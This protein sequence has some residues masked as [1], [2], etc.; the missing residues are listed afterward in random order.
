[1]PSKKSRFSGRWEERNVMN[2]GE[3]ISRTKCAG[4]LLLAA[5]LQCLTAREA[6]DAGFV[7]VLTNNPVDNTVIQYS[8]G[9]DGLLSKLSEVSTE[10]VGGLGNGVGALDPLGS[11]DSLVLTGAGSLLLAVSAGSNEVSSL[12]ASSSGLGFVSKVSSSGLFPNSVAVDRTLVYVLNAHTPNIVGFR[13]NSGVLHPIPGAVFTIPGG[14]NA[15]PHDIRFSP[16]GTRLVVTVEGT[17]QI[18]VFALNTQ[19]LVTGVTSTTAAGSAPFG[20]KFARNGVLVSTEAATAS[21]SSYRLTD[22]DTLDAISPAVPNGQ[23]A[24]CWISFTGDGKF[25]FVSNTASGTLS[26]YQVAGNGTLNLAQAVTATLGVGG[27]PIDSALSDDSRF[28]YVVDSAL[29]RV[30]FF[31]VSGASLH[32]LGSVTGLPQTVQG[33]AAQ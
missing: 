13:L 16:D 29:G 7:Y 14:T 6:S 30:V 19:G 26:T 32:I 4:F 12:S 11:Q 15:K 17:N 8:R 10:G 9:S 1:M 5:S 22:Q 24:S 18:L 3:F 28:L 33:I 21:A 27:A 23:A 2:I 31:R 25:G 20:F